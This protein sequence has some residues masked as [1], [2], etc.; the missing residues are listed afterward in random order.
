[1][2]LYSNI[3]IYEWDILAPTHWINHTFIHNLAEYTDFTTDVPDDRK[4]FFEVIAEYL[5]NNALPITILSLIIA[6]TVISL[7]IIRRQNIRRYYEEFKEIMREE[8]K[9]KIKKKIN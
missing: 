6:A 2:L 8:K 9:E 5:I 1:V 3:A 4:G 7:L